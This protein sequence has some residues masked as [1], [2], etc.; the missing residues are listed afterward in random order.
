[1]ILSFPHLMLFLDSEVIIKKCKISF[2]VIEDSV[3]TQSNVIR[4]SAFQ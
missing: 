4:V 3:H 2:V 1:V